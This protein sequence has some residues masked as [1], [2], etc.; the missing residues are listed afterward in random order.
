MG[1][2]KECRNSL[3]VSTVELLNKE[4]VIKTVWVE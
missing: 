4:L 3:G 2:G 1:L